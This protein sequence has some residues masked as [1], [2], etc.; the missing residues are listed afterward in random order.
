MWESDRSTRV[1]AAGT[2]YL[3]LITVTIGGLLRVFFVRDALFN[4]HAYFLIN[5]LYSQMMYRP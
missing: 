1:D 2:K 3:Y 4:V 5:L